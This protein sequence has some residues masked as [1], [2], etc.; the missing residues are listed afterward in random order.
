MLSVA[1]GSWFSAFD[2]E[3]VR[4]YWYRFPINQLGA[5]SFGFLLFY[6]LK[7]DFAQRYLSD[8]KL[9]LSMLLSIGVVCILLSLSTIPFPPKHLVYSAFFCLIAVLLSVVPWQ[10][11]VN[12]V[13]IFL[14]RISYSCYLLHFFVLK[15]VM[16]FMAS[17]DLLIA[18]QN[19]RF[20]VILVLTFLIT[21]P[22]AYVSYRVLE[23]PAT[24]AGRALISRRGR[25]GVKGAD[26]T[27]GI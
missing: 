4:L 6:I 5:F 1:S 16:S 20:M 21:M 27:V 22:L 25:A 18:N 14:G 10:F 26:N 7:G 24:A 13:T 19:L 9:N 23:L 2:A 17:H 12:R 11:I 8:K 3:L 15:E